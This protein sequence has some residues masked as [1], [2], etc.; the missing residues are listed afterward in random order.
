MSKLCDNPPNAPASGAIM[1][2]AEKKAIDE[3]IIKLILKILDTLI[4]ASHA[5]D[6]IPTPI[7]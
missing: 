4:A 7:F 2:K 1:L 6:R 3:P 5:K